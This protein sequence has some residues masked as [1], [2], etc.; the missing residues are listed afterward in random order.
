MNNYAY[1]L[2]VIGSVNIIFGLYVLFPARKSQAVRFLALSIIFLGLWGVGLA[3]FLASKEVQTA[4]YWSKFH[5]VASI[6]IAYFILAFV[7]ALTQKKKVDLRT[8]FLLQIPILLV[9]WAVVFSDTL[10][11]KDVLIEE[12]GNVALLNRMGHITYGLV[13]VVYYLIALLI[14]FDNLLKSHG[15]VKNQL[16]LILLGFLLTGF[17]GGTFNLILPILG[18]YKLIWVGPQF[19]IIFLGLIFIAIVKY[20]LFNIRLL[21]GKVLYIL[22]SATLLY[23]TFRVFYSIHFSIFGEKI[24][25]EAVTF[26]VVISILF[27]LIYDRYRDFFQEKISSRI[28]NLGYEASKYI[29]RFTYSL[30]NIVTEDSVLKE[31]QGIIKE[32]INPV[33]FS[34]IVK[35]ESAVINK[36]YTGNKVFDAQQIFDIV[37]SPLFQGKTSIS[38]GE[39]IGVFRVDDEAYKAQYYDLINLLERNDLHLL[40]PVYYDKELVAVFVLGK[41]DLNSTMYIGQEISFLQS[42]ASITGASLARATLYQQVQK[43][44]LNLQKDV[45]EKTKELQRNVEELEDARRKE[46]DMLD[47]MGHELRTPAT[48]VKLNTDLLGKFVKNNPESFKKYI[49]RIRNSIENEIR[50][51][52]TLLSSA[53]LEGKKI[54]LNRERLSLP[55]QIENVLHGY[56][57]QIK[58]KGLR[59][60]VDLDDNT[61]DVY[62]DKVRVVEIIDNLLSNSIKYTDTGSIIIKTDSTDD[63]VKVSVIDSGK[64]IPEKEIP[65]LG[66]KFHRI[67]NYITGGSNFNI[68]RPGG[69]GL[70]LY[71]VYALIEMMGGK[72]WVHSQLGKGTTFTFTLPVYKGQGSTVPRVDKK[73]LFEKFGLK[74]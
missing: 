5:Y 49:D 69:T 62:A 45:N 65:R 30:G 48:I 60:M 74:R 34:I 61:K 36:Q 46:R 14:N 3:G 10:I 1:A 22:G 59:V 16:T 50:L 41:R 24:G 26:G 70:G 32:T 51:I 27:T 9:S 37:G 8:L 68:V 72:I 19:S 57:Y 4:L 53:K 28:I 71:V 66:T 20:Q 52:D 56:E 55:E 29:D 43:F 35:R 18:N 67:E 73:N 2:I 31:L 11:I 15:I 54:E 25:W 33:Y 42:L 6:Y 17:L 44:N 47:I 63:Y 7:I 23:T 58:Q 12:S 21:A 39:L 64:G 40:I 38:L 13:F